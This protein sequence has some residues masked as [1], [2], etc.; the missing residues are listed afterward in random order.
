MSPSSNDCTGHLKVVENRQNCNLVTKW[1][2]HMEQ[3]VASSGPYFGKM[4]SAKSPP[5]QEHQR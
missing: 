2:E 4:R 5:P 3:C 1:V